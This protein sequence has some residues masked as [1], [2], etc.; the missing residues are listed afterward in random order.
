MNSSRNS[1]LPRLFVPASQLPDIIGSDAH[2]LRN[3]LRVEVG[4]RLELFDGTGTNYQVEIVTIDKEKISCEIKTKEVSPNEP[5]IKTTLAQALPKSSKM[6]FVIEKAVELGVDQIIPVLTERTIA[7]GDK[8]TRWQKIAK[9]AAEQSGRAIVPEIKPLIKFDDL[10]KLR[11]QYDL[12]IVPWENEKNIKLKS[13]LTDYPTNKLL[14]LIGPEG[15]FSTGEIEM[16]KTAGF[17]AVSLGKRI[18]RTETAG[19]TTLSAIF[20]ELDW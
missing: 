16:A 8:S 19:L 20:Y 4:N 10:L 14:L 11:D 7:K 15:G 6:D 9:E 1:R 12:A 18:L 3:V 2:Y 17:T 13:V 5:K